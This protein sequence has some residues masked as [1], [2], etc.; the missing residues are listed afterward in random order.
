MTANQSAPCPSIQTFHVSGL[1]HPVDSRAVRETFFYRSRMKLFAIRKTVAAQCVW[2]AFALSAA[3]VVL[4]QAAFDPPANNFQGRIFS[5]GALPGQKASLT[6]F[7]F[8]PGQTITVRY[9]ERTLANAVSVNADGGFT[10]E[11]AIPAQATPGLYPVVVQAVKPTAAL[12]YDLKVSPEVPL[13]GQNRYAL[14]SQALRA[15][16]YQVA[17]GTKSNSLFVTTAV[18]RSPVKESKLLKLDPN[19]LKI[20]AERDMAQVPGRSDGHRFAVYGVAVDDAKGTVWATNTRD[21]TVAVYQQSDLSLVKQLEP[22]ALGARPRDVAVDA[23]L[24]KAYVSTPSDPQVVV[25]DTATHTVQKTIAIQSGVRGGVFGSNSLALDAQAHKLYTVSSATNEIAI[26]NTRSDTVE[27][28]IKVD[29]VKGAIGV[30]VDP[31][32]QR[33]FV[34]AQ[35]SDNV[36]VVDMVSGKTLTTVPVGA[37]TL[38]VA[39]DPVSQRAYV[40]NR[41]AGTVTVLDVDGRIVANLPGGSFTNHA[42]VDGKGAIYVVNKARGAKD[43]QGDR[44]TRIVPKS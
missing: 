27:K 4:A 43:P 11:V 30:A 1:S 42:G 9:G 12:V 40:S 28:L 10:A 37:G 33:V 17:Y 16:L 8:V 23:D 6:G 31:K 32:S 15:G 18:G 21:S 20:V 36:A 38:N 5:A 35:G 24:G 7:G 39:F 2:A 19:S 41:G 22:N 13:S 3:P 14:N 29:G 44:I 26:I 34:A 25:L